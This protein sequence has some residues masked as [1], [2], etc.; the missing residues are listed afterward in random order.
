[1]SLFNRVFLALPA[2]LMT[3][4]Y[5]PDNYKLSLGLVIDSE[6]TLPSGKICVPILSV[7]DR[8]RFST[9]RTGDCLLSIG[10]DHLISQ[11]KV[12]TFVQNLKSEDEIKITFIRDFQELEATGKPREKFWFDDSLSHDQKICIA[13][14]RIE[15]ASERVSEKMKGK[16]HRGEITPQDYEEYLSLERE[17][18]AKRKAATAGCAVQ[19]DR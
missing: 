7:H 16:F 3:A 10:G 8:S 12:I 15:Q 17:A 18:I 19:G 11:H 6:K 9:L 1:M 14:G 4:A 2:L 5:S 13:W